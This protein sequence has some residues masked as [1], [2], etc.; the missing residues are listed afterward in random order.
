[1]LSSQRLQHLVQLGHLRHGL[2]LS[3]DANHRRDDDEHGCQAERLADEF[4]DPQIAQRAHGRDRCEQKSTEKASA[5]LNASEILDGLRPR[6]NAVNPSA[7]L[8]D[9]LANIL[10]RVL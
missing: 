1:M 6:T 3:L 8:H 5:S 2:Y 4:G 10:R 9:V 7:N